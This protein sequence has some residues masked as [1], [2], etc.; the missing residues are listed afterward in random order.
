MPWPA[1]I[2]DP[3][4][5]A[6]VT[7]PNSMHGPL[8]DSW[9]TLHIHTHMHDYMNAK[10]EALLYGDLVRG[11]FVTRCPQPCPLRVCVFVCAAF[12]LQS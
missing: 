12:R 2:D 3:S 5:S 6:P 4:T 9:A 11:Q 8:E 7:V 1:W 10:L